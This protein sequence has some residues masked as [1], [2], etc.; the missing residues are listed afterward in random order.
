MKRALWVVAVVFSL[1]QCTGCNG[2]DSVDNSKLGSLFRHISTLL[3]QHIEQKEMRSNVCSEISS[4]Y[5]Y[6]GSGWGLDR[7]NRPIPF[8]E[9]EDTLKKYCIENYDLGEYESWRQPSDIEA[10]GGITWCAFI[11]NCR[12]NHV[13][14][15]DIDADGEDEIIVYCHDAGG[16]ESWGRFAFY[17]NER[18]KWTHFFPSDENEKFYDVCIPDEQKAWIRQSLE[19]TKL[20]AAERAKLE[21]AITYMSFSSMTVLEDGSILVC[22][23][24]SNGREPYDESLAESKIVLEY[25]WSEETEEF[26]LLNYAM[27]VS[28]EDVF[29]CSDME[30]YEKVVEVTSVLR[31]KYQEYTDWVNESLLIDREQYEQIFYHSFSA[32]NIPS[33][34]AS[35]DILMRYA[36]DNYGLEEGSAPPA[37]EVYEL[38]PQLYYTDC[39]YNSVHEYDIDKDGTV[40]TILGGSD[41]SGSSM[42]AYLAFYDDE[43]AEWIHLIPN[44]IQE[45]DYHIRVP[46]E[47]RE[48]IK[49]SLKQKYLDDEK[50]AKLEAGLMYMDCISPT[51]MDDGS[52]LVKFY[53]RNDC[54]PYEKEYIVLEVILQYRWSEELENFEL[55]NYALF[56]EKDNIFACSDIDFIRNLSA[57]I[58]NEDEK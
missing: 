15:R 41:G 23:N 43:K 40:E 27:C 1:M 54:E 2:T 13:A 47:Q 34:E 26:E 7:L 29:A 5:N 19:K 21:D 16:G 48:W 56:E 39:R 58:N 24:G 49:Q 57:I 14:E 38:Y 28:G 36:V 11:T 52:I 10:E 51:L 42:W 9:I 33:M 18:N 20:N 30:F 46:D 3:V 55:V 37:G 53:G 32:K 4:A 12:H 50:K 25:R 6:I 31:G 8:E 22:V 45:K 44:N 17:D 35:E